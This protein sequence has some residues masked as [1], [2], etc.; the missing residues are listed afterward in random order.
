MRV[1]K[2]MKGIVVNDEFE[3][4]YLMAVTLFM[5]SSM[6]MIFSALHTPY[7]EFILLLLLVQ[8]KER[9]RGREG[10]CVDK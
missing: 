3:F 10:G 8:N 1:R 2:E 7:F 9:K 4:L 6:C 5:T